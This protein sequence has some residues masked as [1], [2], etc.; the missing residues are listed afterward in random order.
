M[1][2]SIIVNRPRR[3]RESDYVDVQVATLI[4]DHEGEDLCIEE[5][6][7]AA[8][9]EMPRFTWTNDK[10]RNAVNRLEKRGRIASK[11]VIREARLCRVPYPI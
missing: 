5:L 3:N 8:E 1:K 6:V 2:N 4:S 7:K 9:R 11:H 10:I